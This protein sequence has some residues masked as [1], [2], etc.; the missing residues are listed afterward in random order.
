MS[1][2]KLNGSFLFFKFFLLKEKQEKQKNGDKLV[3]NPQNV[4][5]IRTKTDLQ[6][7]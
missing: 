1:N 6:T 3:I 7:P 5:N 2:E 4:Y